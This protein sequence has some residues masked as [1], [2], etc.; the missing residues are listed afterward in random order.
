MATT[1][2]TRR[3]VFGLRPSILFKHAVIY[4]VMFVVMALILFPIY[5][6]FTISLKLPREIYRLPSLWVDNATLDNYRRLIEEKQ[7]LTNI[8]N[9][10]IVASAVTVTALI[11]SSFAAYS[12]VRFKYRFKGV[13]GRLILFAYLT[14]T[15]LLFIPLSIIVAR[16]HLG[17]SLHGLIIVYLTFALPLSTW[18]LTGYFRGVP[19]ELEEQAMVDGSTRLG[20]LFRILLPLSAPGL[21]AVGIFTFTG[22]WNELLL[23]L[24]FITSEDKRTV[25]LAIQ[26]LITSDD[27]P[28]GPLMAG[29][30]FSALP[31]IILYFLAQRFMVQGMTAGSV[32]G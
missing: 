31:V 16:L 14:P 4:V 9:S 2:K 7:F 12:V 18:L 15:S 3:S 23:A 5:W 11:V 21:V 26:Y 17:N 29:A 19:A 1:P 27:R 22:A 32:K 6:M 24:I 28:W 30:I 25:P 8:R 10:L 13:I 20:A